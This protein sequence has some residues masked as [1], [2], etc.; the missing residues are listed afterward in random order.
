MCTS[1]QDAEL[2]LNNLLFCTTQRVYRLI[3][4]LVFIVAYPLSYVM[5]EVSAISQLLRPFGVPK[6]ENLCLD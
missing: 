6:K 1:L 3:C 2:R 4:A 5:L